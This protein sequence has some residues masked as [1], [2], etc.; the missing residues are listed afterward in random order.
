ML[1]VPLGGSFSK[2]F[3]VDCSVIATTE[4]ERSAGSI[5]AGSDGRVGVEGSRAG[6]AGAGMGGEPE[7]S[8]SRAGGLGGRAT[9]SRGR[10]AGG[11]LLAQN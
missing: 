3:P 7:C 10:G 2:V 6:G 8:G 4:D 1:A 9:R 11:R 5:R